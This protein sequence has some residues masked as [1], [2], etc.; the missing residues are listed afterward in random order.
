MDNPSNQAYNEKNPLILGMSYALWTDEEVTE[1]MIDQHLFP[2]ILGLAEQ[3]WHQENPL[4]FTHFYQHVLQKKGWFEQQGFGF[5]PASKSE[6][7]KDY[8]WD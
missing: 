2:R 7:E 4:N 3:M 8:K 6:V 1:G 5:G